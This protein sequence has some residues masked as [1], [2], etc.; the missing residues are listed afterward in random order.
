MNNIDIIRVT[1]VLIHF[2]TN[3]KNETVQYKVDP[4]QGKIFPPQTIYQ[5]FSKSSLRKI[6]NP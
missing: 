1:I 6:K 3:R 2:N 5:H 4:F